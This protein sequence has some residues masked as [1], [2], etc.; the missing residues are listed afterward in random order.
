MKRILLSLLLLTF[1]SIPTFISNGVAKDTIHE[2]SKEKTV[3]VSK[4]AMLATN[5]GVSKAVADKVMNV[6]DTYGDVAL[7]ISL[8]GLIVGVGG[9]TA[10]AVATARKLAAKYGRASAVAW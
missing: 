4:G 8:I 2:L 1:L 6:I 7:I 9:I 3:N 5:L 10:V